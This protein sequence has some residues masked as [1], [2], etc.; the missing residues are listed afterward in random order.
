VAAGQARPKE[1]MAQAIAEFDEPAGLIEVLMKNAAILVAAK[2]YRLATNILRGVLIRRPDHSDALLQMG[3]C[4]R[5]EGRLDEALKCFRAL[6]RQSFEGQV[7]V[8]ETYYLS[9]RDDLALAS[10]RE[11]LKRVV[12]NSD[13]LF[14]IYKNIGNIH[15]RAGDF[16]AAEEFYNKAYTIHPTSD[17]LMVNYGTLEIQRGAFAEAV[18]RFRRAVDLNPSND[19]AWVGLGLVHRQ[20]GDQ[21]LSWANIQRA[22]DINGKNR[23]AIRLIFDW[24]VTDGKWNDTIIR[25]QSYLQSDGGDAEV[26]FMLAK[27]F[28]QIGRYP[29]ARIELERVLALDPAIEGGEPLRIALDAEIRKQCSRSD[30]EVAS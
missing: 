17:V 2:E 16:E 18:E 9:E 23:T 21:E 8:A 14:E 3:F 19:K 7:L 13:L 6:A 12:D 26:G 25:L 1:Q 29:E 22:L 10:Y 28:T 27:V 5:E 4:L 30:T 15:V 24:G 11:V 20:M